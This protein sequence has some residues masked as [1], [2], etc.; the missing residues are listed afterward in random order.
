MCILDFVTFFI[1]FSLLGI[2]FYTPSF[3]ATPSFK[4]QELPP[5]KAFPREEMV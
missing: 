1:Q 4:A 5:L 2:P 3:Q